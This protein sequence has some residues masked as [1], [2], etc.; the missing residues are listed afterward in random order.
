MTPPQYHSTQK[1]HSG[2]SVFQ[3]LV[4]IC[5]RETLSVTRTVKFAVLSTASAGKTGENRRKPGKAGYLRLWTTLEIFSK[6]LNPH[7]RC[8]ISVAPS[9]YHCE[10]LAFT[11]CRLSSVQSVIRSNQLFGSNTESSLIE[12]DVSLPILIL[13]L[14]PVLLQ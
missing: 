3:K 14:D 13:R 4:L 12:F 5:G 8:Q 9:A 6:V 2:A 11:R 7:P 1:H 10:E